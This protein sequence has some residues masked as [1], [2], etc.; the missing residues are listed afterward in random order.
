MNV[1]KI[2][3][4]R[5]GGHVRRCHCFPHHGEY[6]VAQHSFHMLILLEE[7]HPDPPLALYSAILR[8]DLY[9]RWTGDSPAAVKRIVPE[10]RT[11]THQAEQFVER[12][13]GIER[14]KHG[15]LGPD[16]L[17]WVKALDNLEFLMWC[18]DQIA[19]GSKV[20]LEK[21]VEVLDWLEENNAYIPKECR[22]FLEQYS[23]QRTKDDL[24]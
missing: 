11:V 8:H 19:L 18:N 10:F 20:A 13:T 1:L 3:R 9:E 17:R 16:N 2:I 7:L 24:L 23:W 12:H 21:R 22:E 4:M 6:D 14:W 5:E 15:V